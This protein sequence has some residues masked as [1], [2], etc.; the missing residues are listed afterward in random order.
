MGNWRRPAAIAR[1]GLCG[2]RSIVQN[3]QTISGRPVWG[4]AWQPPAS[5]YKTTNPAGRLTMPPPIPS[6]KGND[7]RESPLADVVGGVLAGD[8]IMASRS[9]IAWNTA[10]G[11]PDR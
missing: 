9:I 11:L 3:G 10:L 2:P 4:P 8:A 1:I 6:C 7:H 5:R